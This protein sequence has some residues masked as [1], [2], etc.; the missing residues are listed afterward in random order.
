MY[1]ELGKLNSTYGKF[2]WD[3]IGKMFKLLRLVLC[4]SETSK[5]SLSYKI[6]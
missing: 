5:I 3:C 2:K 6:I 4:S 1:S